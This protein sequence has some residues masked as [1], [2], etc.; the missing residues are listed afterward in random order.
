MKKRTSVQRPELL[1]PRSNWK[2][3]RSNV[4]SRNVRKKPL[5]SVCRK[6][7]KY[8]TSLFLLFVVIYG[9]SGGA[10]YH[11][12]PTR[13]DDFSNMLSEEESK[14]DNPLL[15]DERSI[16]KKDIRTLLDSRRFINIRNKQFDF[17]SEGHCFQVDTTLDIPLQN[18]LLEKLDRSTA[19][20]IGIVAME[21]YTGRVLSMVSFD[22][23]DP[24]NNLCTDSRFPAASVFKIVTAAAV[25]EKCGFN[26]D[27]KIAYSGGKHTLYK[28]QLKKKSK[29]R[30]MRDITLR[31]SFAQSVNPVFGKIG[32]HYL[33]KDALEAYA[34]AFGFNQDIGFEIPVAPSMITVFDDPY[35]WAEVASGFNRE[36]TISPLHGALMVST[37]LNHGRLVEPVLVEEILDD[38]GKLLYQSEPVTLNRVI[39]SDASKIVKR[40]M[41][42]TIASGTCRKAFRGYKKDT[43]LSRLNIGGKTGTISN[44]KRDARY[45]WFVGFAEEKQGPGTIVISAVV[46]HGKYIGIKAKQYARFAIKEYFNNYFEKQKRVQN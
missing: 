29:R 19:R 1:I 26:S 40:L 14:S 34:D 28:S 6:I 43:V 25:I 18:F 39:T 7:F 21:P 8:A 3:Y 46:A 41:G 22:E 24:Y 35:H 11:Y 5:A 16:G 36:T 30:R 10:V 4:K 12:M 15:N 38:N 32:V 31:D 33:G 13:P 37:I 20:Y 27:S 17:I 42:A 2:Y 44:K 23:N 9:I 45:D